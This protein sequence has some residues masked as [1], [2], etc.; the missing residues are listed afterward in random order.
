VYSQQ[1]DYDKELIDLV[2]TDQMIDAVR[3]YTQYQD[4]IRHPFTIDSYH[5]MEAFHSNHLED[6]TEI[7]PSF[8]DKYYGNPVRDDHLPYFINSSLKS[9]DYEKSLKIQEIIESFL[10]GKSVSEETG[11][12]I[13]KQGE[14]IR[15]RIYILSLMEVIN[16][17]KQDVHI[18]LQSESC[19]AFS[20]QY[21]Q[22]SLKT[23]FDTG[24]GSAFF[25]NKKIAEKIGV[26]MTEEYENLNSS[27]VT[28]KYGIIDSVRI[29]SILIKNAPVLVLDGEYFERCS[30]ATVS[31]NPIEI[32]MGLPLMKLL[33]HIQIDWQNREMTI[34]LNEK[35]DNTQESNMYISSLS[36]YI[37]TKINNCDYSILFDTGAI[38]DTLS[39]IID[40]E[41]YQNHKQDLPV[42]S[43]KPDTMRNSC[44][45]HGN[46]SNL[47]YIKPTHLALQIGDN[48]IDIQNEAIILTGDTSFF[49]L[50]RGLL[51]FGL[52]RKI[53]TLT[54]NFKS[55][56]LDCE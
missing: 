56:R 42:V 35:E 52:F 26:K 44:A 21:N 10:T 49:H 34:S 55:M 40:N 7:L 9:L 23:F 1:R 8:L 5:I 47:N 30:N 50:N 36:L 48:T 25:V 41:F 46:I 19:I 6:A 3:Y 17:R 11:K 15:K 24:V 12:Y 22:E 13:V 51:G 16:E 45:I 2:Y 38:G 14:W 20:A 53:K 4:S 27:E 28:A 39:I 31:E 18:P 54:L 32:F 37:N 33:N 43:E 29:G